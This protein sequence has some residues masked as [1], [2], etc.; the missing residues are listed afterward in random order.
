[1][2]WRAAEFCGCRMILC[3]M[4][5]GIV[6]LRCFRLA[7]RGV[8]GRCAMLRRAGARPA[9]V[10]GRQAGLHRCEE[11]V[12]CRSLRRDRAGRA[13]S[14]R[15][16][17]R[18]SRGCLASQYLATWV[19]TRTLGEGAA[20]DVI[21]YVAPVGERGPDADVR[22]DQPLE[23]DLPPARG[24]RAR[25]R[26]A[27]CRLPAHG[28]SR[29]AAG[30]SDRP[31]PSRGGARRAVAQQITL[32]HS[33][34]AGHLPAAAQHETEQGGAHIPPYEERGTVLVECASR[35]E[36][37]LPE[38][39]RRCRRASTSSAVCRLT[40]TTARGPPRTGTSAGTATYR[41]IRVGGHPWPWLCH[42]WPGTRVH[43][44]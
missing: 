9:G 18:H 33:R 38:R 14:R 23:Q 1:M 25:R 16:K 26:P 44:L 43:P 3:L 17:H 6:S 27:H 29:P 37:P 12:L 32:D 21:G 5:C 10:A 19:V 42:E 24:L 2:G 41:D 39:S 40:R 31:V 20:R 11:P 30:T 36:S 8:G 15:G 35:S 28:R 4:I 13:V 34:E 7:R 22:R